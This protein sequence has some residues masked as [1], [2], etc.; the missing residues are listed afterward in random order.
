VEVAEVE[1]AAATLI[2]SRK[3]EGVEG[4]VVQGGWS[5]NQ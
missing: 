5:F 2:P 1:V 3:L 4:A